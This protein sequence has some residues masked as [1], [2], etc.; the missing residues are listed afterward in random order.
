MAERVYNILFVCTGNSNRS[1]MAESIM[2]SLA[3]GRFNVYSAGSHPKGFVAPHA[4][5]A[6]ARAELPTDGLRSKN[7]SEF[8][9]P[10]APE[11]DL[12]ITVCDRAAGE[13]CP[14][15]PG[16]PV[17]ANWS[18]PDPAATVGSEAA[19]Q[20]AYRVTRNLLQLRVSLLLSLNLDKLDRLALQSRVTAISQHTKSETV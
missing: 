18:V 13:P 12:I 2:R 16:A 1:I 20:Q 19:I 4:I 3:K 14:V 9:V 8:A 6:L 7:W 5:E 17:T 15:W 11:M 10:G